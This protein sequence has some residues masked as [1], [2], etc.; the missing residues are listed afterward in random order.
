LRDILRVNFTRACNEVMKDWPSVYSRR[1]SKIAE[2]S[3]STD[4]LERVDQ[5]LQSIVV[6]VL[7]DAAPLGLAGLAHPLLGQPALG[8]VLDNRDEI[9]GVSGGFPDEGAGQFD[10]HHRPVFAQVAL[11]HRVGLYLPGEQAP[12][13]A[14]DRVEVVGM[15]DVLEGEPQ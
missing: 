12:D 9:L 4:L 5:A 11:L 1:S 8:D 15:G 7:G 10:P 6:D 2:R 14:Q 3:P 13:V